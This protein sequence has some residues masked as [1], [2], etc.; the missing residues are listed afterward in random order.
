MCFESWVLTHHLKFIFSDFPVSHAK[1][2]KGASPRPTSRLPT[3][4]PGPPAFSY[5]HVA[6]QG[7]GDSEGSRASRL[8]SGFH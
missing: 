1:E 5:R 4:P 6:T 3:H 7:P 8:M 2:N